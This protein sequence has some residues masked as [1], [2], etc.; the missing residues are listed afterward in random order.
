MPVLGALATA[1]AV[2]LALL[3]LDPSVSRTAALAVGLVLP[4][5]AW[6]AFTRLAGTPLPSGIGPLSGL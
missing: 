5:L 4:P 2:T 1:T 3:L 6:L